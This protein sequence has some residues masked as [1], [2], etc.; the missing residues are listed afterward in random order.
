[1][2]IVISIKLNEEYSQ[3]QLSISQDYRDDVANIELCISRCEKFDEIITDDKIIQLLK[4]E[5]IE[6]ESY[7]VED[8][9]TLDYSMEIIGKLLASGG[10]FLANVTEM[11]IENNAITV[12]YI[13]QN[14][15]ILKY[16]LFLD[17]YYAPSS[18]DLAQIDEYFM[19]LSN[20]KIYIDGNEKPV[21]ILEYK[22]TIAAINEIVSKI[23]KYS[24]SPLEQIMFAYDLVR[25]RVYV[26]EED[27]EE[28]FI[29]RD[30]TSVLSGDKIVC[31]GFANILDKVLKNLGI[32]SDMIL[33][34]NKDG[35]TGHVR[36]IIY[37]MDYKYDVSGLYY[38]DPT[39]DSKKAEDDTNY[40][41][42]YTYFC[43]T[44]DEMDVLSNIMGHDYVDRRFGGFEKDTV[45]KFESIVA[46]N[47]V[48]AIPK[49]MISAF[50]HVSR[51]IDGTILIYPLSLYD[52]PIIPE[53]IKKSF[54]YEEVLGKISDYKRIIYDSNLTAMQLLEIL[55]KVR[56][57]EF[58]EDPLKYPYDMD[59][60][61][62]VVVDR[63]LNDKKL[64]NSLLL[65]NSIFGERKTLKRRLSQEQFDD[66]SSNGE[67]EKS[68]QQIRLVKTLQ[69][70][71]NKK[72]VSS[73]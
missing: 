39:W 43:R 54:N 34:L 72:I 21:S 15:E 26:A 6:L 8:D 19:S 68:I 31:V 36:N 64:L 71:H 29:S 62:K 4:E 13:K 56:K 47:G 20:L 5:L 53:F 9:D 32:R 70:I 69:R 42:S 52:S 12:E 73:K 1:M 27:D 66:I 16:P 14:P 51:F 65:L 59:T 50:N 7:K 48:K 63:Y 18:E 45:S 57:I 41:N 17:G 11:I 30:L 37:V 35:K 10:G 40:L 58:Y 60:I 3:P 55:M 23:Q 24:L 61:K 2:D 33:L 46:K 38:L 28:S 22:N 67:L 25:D 44:R 49:D